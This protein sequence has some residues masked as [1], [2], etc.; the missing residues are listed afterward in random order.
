MAAKKKGLSREQAAEL[1]KDLQRAMSTVRNKKL[2]PA[3]QSAAS[4]NVKESARLIAKEISSAMSRDRGGAPAEPALE[5]PRSSG[6]VVD[7]G[8]TLAISLIVLFALT[9]VAFSALEAGGFASVSP[10]QAAIASPAASPFESKNP[11]SREEF[12]ILTSLD[13]RRV[14]LEERREKLDSR[15]K[16][17]ELRD[18]EFAAK[19]T[20]LR[21]LTETLKSERGKNEKKRDG[22]LDQLANVYGSMNPQEAAALIEQLDVTIA[23]SLLERMPEK[24]IGQIL[25]LMKPE[26]ALTLTKMLSG[27]I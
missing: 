7:R 2:T 25:A 3:G 24:R 13:A 1:Y 11:Y 14:E 18:R 15:E 22:Q 5:L 21:E 23:L 6:S 8:K 19:L 9:K 12:A 16:D 20:Q 10:A 17:L 4:S 26:K 27:K